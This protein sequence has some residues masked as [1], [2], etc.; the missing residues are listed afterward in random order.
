MLVCC[1]VGGGFQSGGQGHQL[2]DQVR[3]LGDAEERSPGSTMARPAR[4]ETPQSDSTRQL[5]PLP[6]DGDQPQG[7]YVTSAYLF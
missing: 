1:R 4:E 3:S 7:I 5:P 6:H 2:G